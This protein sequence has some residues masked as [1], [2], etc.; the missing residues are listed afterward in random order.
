MRRTIG[1]VLLGIW[2]AACG[3]REEP[4]SKADTATQSVQPSQASIEQALNHPDRL[5]G[6]AEQDSW[7]KPQAVLALLDLRPG[8]QVIDY[9]AGGGY[10]TELL[11]RIVGPGGQV[12]AYNN[13]SYAKYAGDKPAQR[14]GND[15]LPN[16][17]QLTTAPEDLPLNPETLD[18][19]LFVQSYH[20]LHW[21][22]KDGSWPQT[23][24]DAALAKL[25]A[26][27]KP[28]AV[29]VVVDHVAESGSDPAVSV[30]TLHRIDPEVIKR[31]FAA[32]GFELES[33]S[34]ALRNPADDHELGVFDEAIRHKTD[35]VIYKFRKK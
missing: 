4:S 24:P 32:A 3:Q 26:A 35:Q 25:A 5:P 14:Y 29:V 7:R 23:D 2:L 33:E 17:A 10:Y 18:A 1:I 34:D 27:L 22:S 30:D 11:A 15:R 12:I 31:D 16:V 6:D 9:F 8:M 20:D 28:G 21:E 13:P 19:A